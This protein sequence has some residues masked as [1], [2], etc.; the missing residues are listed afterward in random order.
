MFVNGRENM[1]GAFYSAGNIH[2]IPHM[3]VTLE[4]SAS[5]WYV[6]HVQPSVCTLHHNKINITGYHENMQICLKL[7]IKLKTS[8]QIQLVKTKIKGNNYIRNVLTSNII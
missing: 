7:D 1:K 2:F 6:S 3:M 8:Y 4:N 5:C